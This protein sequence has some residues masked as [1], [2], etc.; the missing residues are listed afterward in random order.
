VEI[1]EGEEED[2]KIPE[3]EESHATRGT[4]LKR[5]AS[6]LDSDDEHGLEMDKLED[7][8]TYGADLMGDAA[9]RAR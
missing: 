6:S 2:I 4:S 1:E 8:D 3:Y 7:D 9:D 5:A